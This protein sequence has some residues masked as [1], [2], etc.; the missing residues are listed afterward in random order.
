M[1]NLDIILFLIFI[2]F[3]ILYF[4]NLLV[5]SKKKNIQEAFDNNCSKLTD[6]YI[7]MLYHAND[8]D[9]YIH[10]NKDSKFNKKCILNKKIKLDLI[11]KKYNLKLFNKVI[12]KVYKIDE[13]SFYREL[14]LIISQIEDGHTDLH[15]SSIKTK[16]LHQLE[17]KL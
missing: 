10:C 2:Y 16:L 13:S 5:N 8:N 11:H 14:L 7:F 17:L 6:N 9:I 15:Q 4:V 12:F 3:L 1:I